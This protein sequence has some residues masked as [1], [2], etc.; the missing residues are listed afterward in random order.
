MSEAVA[1]SER[2]VWRARWYAW[3]ALGLGALAALHSR[4]PWLL[5]GHWLVVTVSL[6]TVGVYALSRAWQAP[7]A[8]TMCAGVALT[9]FSG[10]WGLMGLPGFPFLPDRMLLA[11]VVLMIVLRAPGAVHVAHMRVGKV[12]LFLGLLVLYALG[13]AAA[14]GTI[15]TKDGI[16]ALL[17]RLGIV[18]FAMLLLAPAVF[19]EERSRGWLL[20]TLVGLGTYLGVTAIF[21]SIGPHALV[22]P[23]YIVVSDETLP[24]AR[25]GGPF[26]SSVAEG[27]ATFACAVASVIAFTQWRS[28]W[29]W[30]AL[31]VATVCMFACFVTL[32]RG[33]WL[34]AIG[35]TVV[36]ALSTRQGRRLLVPG[37][38]AAALVI[39]GALTL[40]PALASKTSNR[41]GEHRSVWDR[42]NQTSAAFRMIAARPLFGFGW[43]TFEARG[44]DYFREAPD[45]PMSGYSTSQRGIPLHD[46]YLS[47]AVELGLLGA[48]LWLAGTLWGIG[49]A[50]FASGPPELRP[51]KLGL[52][53]LGVFFLIVAS[54]NPLQENFTELLLWTWAGVA[55]GPGAAALGRPRATSAP[56]RA[57]RAAPRRWPAAAPPSPAR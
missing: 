25:A 13:S 56:A 42:R 54:V 49:G 12:H 2:G 44:L 32:E 33:V 20:A 8:I 52:L 4:L 45:Y 38:L 16:F 15:G 29:R 50:I 36:A 19:C 3:I 47:M 43:D 6:L 24:G 31:S 46:I 21:E 23:H 18:P 10:N 26:A 48:L 41:V 37:A 51:W 55:L 22:V 30:Y 27:F 40:S 28:R 53:A 35:G 14:A 9:V 57:E 5:H 11:G 7:A 1:A 34:A 17:D 39:G